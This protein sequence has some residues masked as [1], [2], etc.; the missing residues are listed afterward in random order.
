[1]H[2]TEQNEQ[3]EEDR[4]EKRKTKTLHSGKETDTLRV[5]RASASLL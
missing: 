2:N 3:V 1:M 5:L 4:T